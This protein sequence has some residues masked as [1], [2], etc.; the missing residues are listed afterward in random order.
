AK[1]LLDCLAL[2]AEQDTLDTG[3][4]AKSLEAEEDAELAEVCLFRFGRLIQAL[5]LS[6]G[7]AAEAPEA[8]R[9]RG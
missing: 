4:E 8:K 5:R 7:D 9:A 1:D 3:G 2:S 6:M